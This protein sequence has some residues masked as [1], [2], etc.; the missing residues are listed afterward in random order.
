MWGI[1]IMMSHQSKLQVVSS[2]KE[3]GYTCSHCTIYGPPPLVLDVALL[4]KSGLAF[5]PSLAPSL[6]GAVSC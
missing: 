4:E 3:G 1:K 2:R 5:S 6:P